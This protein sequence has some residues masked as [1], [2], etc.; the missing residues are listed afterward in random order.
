LKSNGNKR[1]QKRTLEG[2]AQ[3][4][5]SRRVQEEFE[6]GQKNIKTGQKNSEK[7]SEIVTSEIRFGGN[8]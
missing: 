8:F 5:R 2:D 3:K 4:A 1:G 6:F 7:I